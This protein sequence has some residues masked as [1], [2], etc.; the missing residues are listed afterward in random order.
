M[1]LAPFQDEQ[2]L[3]P[4]RVLREVR[5]DGSFVLRRP[6]PLQPF[7]R[8]IGDWLEHWASTTP[9]AIFLGERDGEGQWRRMTY[10]QARERI[11]RIAQ[12]LLDARYATGKPVVV[13]SDNAVE[14]ALLGLAAMHVGR[15]F[16]MISS[17]YCRMTKDH[18]KIS[19]ILDM[20]SPALV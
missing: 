10:R 14:A 3:A 20:L 12:G 18:S 13:L 1:E 9:D 2:A 16:C 4:P 19:G 17:A 15:P 5:R 8:C 6:E 11:G 7:A